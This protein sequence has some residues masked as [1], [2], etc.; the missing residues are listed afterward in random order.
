ME[1]ESWEQGKKKKKSKKR[2]IGNEEMVNLLKGIGVAEEE[3]AS[4]AGSYDNGLDNLRLLK[5][6]RKGLRVSNKL[7]ANLPVEDIE[8]SEASS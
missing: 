8:A 6:K 7:F 4:E 2:T 5:S 1:E 3:N